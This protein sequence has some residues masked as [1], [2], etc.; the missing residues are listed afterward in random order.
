MQKKNASR[1]KKGRA[2]ERRMIAY[3]AAAGVA[4]ALA[5]QVDAAVIYSGV[6]NIDLL[7]PTAGGATYTLDLD[8]GGA[9]DFFFIGYGTAAAPYSVWMRR[10]TAPGVLVADLRSSNNWYEKFVLNLPSSTTVIQG[11]GQP[12]RY[13][14]ILNARNGAVSYGSFYAPTSGYIGVQFPVGGSNYY[15][16]IQYQGSSLIA[17]SSPGTIIDWAYDDTGAL[18]HISPPPNGAI[19][20]P[21]T[22]GLG[23]L[24]LGAAGVARLRRRRKREGRPAP[25]R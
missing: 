21:A 5:P 25:T 10:A 7:P 2:L 19:P 17:G 23:A 3:S 15:G 22:I 14:G 12:G 13:S 4:L 11:D 20:E 18:F 16:W 24:A 9:P 1:T 6:Q 8:G